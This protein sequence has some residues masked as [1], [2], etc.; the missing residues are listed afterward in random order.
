MAID[1]DEW[2][3]VQSLCDT[4][5][6]DPSEFKY[7]VKDPKELTEA[8][9]LATRLPF[10]D[11]DRDKINQLNLGPRI[12]ELKRKGWSVEG[13]AEHFGLDRHLVGEWWKTFNGMTPRQ[14][15]VYSEVAVKNDIFNTTAAIQNSFEQL[16]EMSD[17]IK[18]NPELWIMYRG[19]IRQH[20]KF[21]ADLIKTVDIEKRRQEEMDIVIEEIRSIAP[22][23]AIKVL[24]R[25]QAVRATRGVLGG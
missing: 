6:Y 14:R 12:V 5:D 4:F 13:I 8:D 2:E 1:A 10:E 9:K 25:I 11:K 22:E 15:Q 20:L 19:E 21:A 3:Q 17:S 23:V 7:T 18:E 24:K 16:N